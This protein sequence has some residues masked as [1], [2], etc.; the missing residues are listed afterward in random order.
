MA[1]VTM[2]LKKLLTKQYLQKIYTIYKV[3]NKIII[4]IAIC[5]SVNLVIIIIQARNR[6]DLTKWIHYVGST[7]IGTEFIIQVKFRA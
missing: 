2:I 1:Y 7:H 6:I 3:K 5:N 4:I